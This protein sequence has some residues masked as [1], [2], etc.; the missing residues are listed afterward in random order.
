MP[1]E[2]QFVTQLAIILCAAAVFTVISKALKQPVILGYILAG[3]LVGPKLG[4]FPQLDAKGVHEWSEIGIIFLMF[5]LGLEFSFRKLLR[6]GSSALITAGV[7]CIGMFIVGLA[8]GRMMGW[9]GMESVFLGGM[10][11]MS[12]TAIIIKA[13]DDMG[14][15]NK[16]YAPLIFG[17]LVFED[18]IAVLL[19]VLLSTM[20]VTGRF[21][22]G[23][24]LME[25]LKLVFFLVLWFVVGMFLLPMIFKKARKFFTNE[26]LLLVGL[27]LCFGMVVF[28]NYVGFSSA[29][30][31]FVMGSILAETLEGTKIEHLTANIK[32]LFAAIFFVSVGIMVDPAVIAEH[33]VTI[34]I[35]SIVVVLGRLVF[36]TWGVLLAGGGLNTAVHASFTLAQLGEFAFILAGLGCSLGVLRP[37]IY[38]IIIAVTVVTTF[39]TP[40]MIRL[41]DTVTKWVYKKVPASTIARLDPA[42]ASK[43]K[44]SKAEKSEWQHLLTIFF[45]RIGLYSVVIIALIFLCNTFLPMLVN[46][47]LQNLL[48]RHLTNL[49]MA[50]GTLAVLSPFLYGMTL[51]D[52]QLKKSFSLLLNKNKENRWI[53]LSMLCLRAIIATSYVIVVMSSYL[54]LYAWEVV[55]LF[56][57]GIVIFMIVARKSVKNINRFEATFLHNLNEK[58]LDARRQAPVTAKVNDHLS[59]YNVLL[60]QITISSD[61]KYVGKT[62]REMPFRKK[63]D[64]NIIK[65]SRGTTSILVPSG[66]EVI[67]PGDILLVVGTEQQLESFEACI[68][69]HTQANSEASDKLNEEFAVESIVVS[70]ESAFCGHTL[71]EIDMRKT[72]CMVISVMRDDKNITNPGAEFKFEVGD[73][74]WLAGEKSALE[75]YK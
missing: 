5:G 47:L 26:I 45:M 15:K 68:M 42:P 54:A 66:S 36:S 48:G 27:A 30:G 65:I 20:A 51:S 37:F 61:F 29:L 32:D 17:S 44:K 33:W 49:I 24:M 62:L 38:P 19:M 14:L 55:I 3:F 35:L 7:K 43:A 72:G 13:Y 18:L 69:E 70:E 9:T 58:E 39:T 50:V 57:I 25:V 75:W 16:P 31:A 60:K 1:E 8:V 71:R 67:Y 41:A 4:L 21:E 59:G 40:Y 11:G 34:L 63:S 74:V 12:S 6:I 64:A 73:M 56:I 46:P 53:L 52:K 22:G 2:L 10:L 28:A 23:Q